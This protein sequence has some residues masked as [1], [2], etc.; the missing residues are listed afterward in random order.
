M[1]K[2]KVLRDAEYVIPPTCTTCIH[3]QWDVQFAH[4]TLVKCT[5]HNLQVS[6]LGSCKYF[7]TRESLVKDMIH[8]T[9]RPFLERRTNPRSKRFKTPTR[10]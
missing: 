3:A 4:T 1:T 8:P 7:A 6:Q 10:Y 5:L 9:D 2:L